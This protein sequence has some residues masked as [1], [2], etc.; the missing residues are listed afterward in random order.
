MRIF[1]VGYHE[2][3]G[4]WGEIIPGY[5]SYARVYDT[6]NNK[7]EKIG[8]VIGQGASCRVNITRRLD[9]GTLPILCSVQKEDAI[10]Y[11]LTMFATLEKSPLKAGRVAGT[12]YRAR[13][14][15][16]GGN[17]L[18]DSS[19]GLKSFF[20]RSFQSKFI[21]ITILLKLNNSICKIKIRQIGEI[22]FCSNSNLS[23]CKSFFVPFTNYR[24]HL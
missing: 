12:D 5:H 3:Y 19:T 20:N 9:A 17:M 23:S 13:Y 22:F 2:N 15:C 24:R 14:A 16:S 21:Y 18:S 1:R 6:E 8:F 11:H 7:Q 10:E 4:Y